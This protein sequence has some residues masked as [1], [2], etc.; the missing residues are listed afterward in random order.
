MHTVEVGSFEPLT[1]LLSKCS[2]RL[3]RNGLVV[4]VEFQRFYL[5][6]SHGIEC[7]A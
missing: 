3:E 4:Y 5:D 2:I 1:S 6:T 7:D